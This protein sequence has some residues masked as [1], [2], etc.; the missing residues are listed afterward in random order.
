MSSFC[1]L[2][3]YSL[4]FKISIQSVQCCLIPSLLIFLIFS[5][6]LFLFIF[7]LLVY[8]L[9]WSFQRTSFWFHWFF[10]I[11]F[12][13][14]FLLFLSSLLLL[15][16]Y[17]YVLECLSETVSWKWCCLSQKGN[18]CAHLLDT[19]KFSSVVAVIFC[20]AAIFT[21]VFL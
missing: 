21:H 3:S 13:H 14:W 11:V 9:Y 2:L 19:V 8:Q 15:H 5:L 7:L 1:F 20:S 12:F 16:L 6:S 18:A 10:S 4:F 17:F